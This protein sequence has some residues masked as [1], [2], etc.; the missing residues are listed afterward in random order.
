M[1][2][3]ILYYGKFKSIPKLLLSNTAAKAFDRV[4]QDFLNKILEHLGLPPRVLLWIRAINSCPSVAVKDNGVPSSP[5]QM[6][7]GTCQGCRLFLLLLIL[8]LETFLCPIRTNANIH[9]I[10]V[11][12][13]QH[14]VATYSDNLLCF[15]TV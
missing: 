5:L 4:A 14:R 15:V 11:S 3:H 7:N 8:M 13:T 12:S 9:G 10:T 1:H 2:P 6:H